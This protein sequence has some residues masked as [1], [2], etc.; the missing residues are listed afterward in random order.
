MLDLERW[1]GHALMALAHGVPAAGRPARRGDLRADAEEL[2]GVRGL[3]RAHIF[4]VSRRLL[5]PVG[6]GILVVPSDGGSP[7]IGCL[8]GAALERLHALRAPLDAE[9]H[10][11]ADARRRSRRR[12]RGGAIPGRDFVVEMRHPARQGRGRPA[13]GFRIRRARTEGRT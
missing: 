8:G 4:M 12:R 11:A 5:V 9:R 3:R 1:G 2:R 10:I 13:P 6:H 7:V